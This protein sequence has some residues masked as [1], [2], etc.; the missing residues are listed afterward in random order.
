MMDRVP[1]SSP[2]ATPVVVSWLTR[3]PPLE[4]S[5]VLGVGDVAVALARRILAEDPGDPPDKLHWMGVAGAGPAAGAPPI[6]AL[7]GD[8]LP[9]MEGVSFFAVDPEAPS[10]LLPTRL[11]PSVSVGLL[12]RIV[13]V[14]RL[15]APVMVVPPELAGASDGLLISAGDARPIDADRLR[16]RLDAWTGATDGRSP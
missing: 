6:L 9:W 11:C 13:T 3:E 2:T 16:A 10:L 7:L 12:Q 8:N 4:P 5:A 15:V 14:R 1:N